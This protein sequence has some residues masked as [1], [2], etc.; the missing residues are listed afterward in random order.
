M[1]RSAHT[2]ASAQRTSNIDILLLGDVRFVCLYNIIE[3]LRL[4]LNQLYAY[5]KLV[6]KEIIKLSEKLDKAI[7][8]YYQLQKTGR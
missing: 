7:N 5:K 4:E 3:E 1:V 8:E 6:D 2:D